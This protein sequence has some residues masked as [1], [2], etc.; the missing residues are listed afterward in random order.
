[1]TIR[2]TGPAEHLAAGVAVVRRV[3]GLR[4]QQVSQVSTCTDTGEK[5]VY[6]TASVMPA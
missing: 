2:V 3:P 5:R 1:M 4:V 6:V